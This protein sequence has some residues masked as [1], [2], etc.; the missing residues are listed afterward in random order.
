MGDVLD[1]DGLVFQLDGLL[2]RNDVH[3]DARPSG[4]NHGGDFLQGQEGHAL[5]KGGDLRGLLNLRMAHIEK[6]RAARHEHGQDI[7]LFV[8]GVFAVQV[9]PVVLN[10]ADQAHLVQQLLQLFRLHAGELLYLGKGL[11][12]AHLHLQGHVGHLVGNQPGQTPV[13]RV[14]PGDAVELGGHPVGNHPAQ[15]EYLL[16]GVV[17][18]GNLKGQFALVQGEFRLAHVVSPL[19]FS[20]ASP[21]PAPEANLP[22]S[23]RPRRS[24]RRWG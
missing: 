20:S 16:P 21:L 23:P 4:R 19:S 3:S 6:L 13:F 11:G 7:P 2:H 1:G 5:K 22:I 12:F 9:L 10:E 8:V 15:L 17:R 18:L 24:W 14:L